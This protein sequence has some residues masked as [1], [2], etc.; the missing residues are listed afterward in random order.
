[1]KYLLIAFL[2][3][4]ALPARAAF[5]DKPVATLRWLNKI[6]AQTEMIDVPI[7]ETIHYGDLAVRVR[8]CRKQDPLEGADAAAFLQIWEK[9]DLGEPRWV[10]SGWMFSSSPGLSAM[11][12]PIYD[13]WPLDCTDGAAKKSDD[14]KRV[15]EGTTKKEEKTPEEK[16]AVKEESAAEENADATEE[17]QQEVQE[18]VQEEVGTEPVTEEVPSEA[19]VQTD[20]VTQTP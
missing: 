10:F 14:D 3:I 5:E 13:V 19:P 11:D 7:G 18:E 17:V 1:M 8:S 2:L 20:S 16:P 15:S 9:D 4:A 12:H 6:T